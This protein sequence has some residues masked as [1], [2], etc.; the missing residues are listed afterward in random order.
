MRTRMVTVSE[1]R[2]GHLRFAQFGVTAVAGSPQGAF[3]ERASG[4]PS[5]SQQGE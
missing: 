5:L 4:G 2:S 3:D 1:V